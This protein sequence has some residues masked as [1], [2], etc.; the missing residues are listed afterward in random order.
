[1][2]DFIRRNHRWVVGGFTLIYFSGLGQTYFISA[3]VA[4]WQDAF[5]LTHGE[6][7]RLYMFAT[8]ASAASLPFAGRL[9]DVISA[10]RTILLVAPLLALAAI[11]AGFATSLP[12]LVLAIYLLRLLGQGM[13]TH[14]ALT[15]TG[16]WFIAER[17]RAISLV[18][19]GHQGGE[20]TI[21]LMF[22][23]L[24]L[25]VGYRAGWIAA[26]L[27]LLLIGL[28]LAYWC[29]RRPRVPFGTIS[30][31]EEAA[32]VPRHWTR[33]EVLRDPVFWVLLTGVLAPGFIST[34]IIYHQDYM[35][36]L[37]D[38]PPQL[39]PS[40]LL[41]LAV[42]TVVVALLMG[43]V[44]DRVGSVRV[45]PFFLLPLAAACVALAFSGP[46][47]MLFVVMILLGVSSGISSMM[48]G[49]LWPEI[50]GVAHL[51]AIRSVTVSA[52]VLATAAGPGLTGTL[53]DA[54][55]PLPSQMFFVGL[56]CLLAAGACTGA[57][58]LL[59]RRA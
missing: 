51:G 12:I 37:N 53:I 19:L 55:V 3:S 52:V 43:A 4:E 18:M 49:S 30:P 9:V 32:P 28:P 35:T 13:M 54:G 5:G 29:Y 39:F 22:A 59:R 44:I 11:L 46:E 14:I 16:R 20:A 48:F 10:H 47:Y 2:L 6:F 34:T 56:Y 36:A 8:L 40:S 23:A 1:M 57:S 42:T 15:A 27:A 33:R 7:G 50:Y 24:T 25:A 26:A 21:P 17:G 41:V 45:L 38:W 58:V 31:E